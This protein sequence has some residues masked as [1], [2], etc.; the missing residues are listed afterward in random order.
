MIYNENNTR[1]KGSIDIGVDTIIPQLTLRNGT[2]ADGYVEA[3][4]AEKFTFQLFSDDISDSV[5]W[6]LQVSLDGTNWATAKDSSDTDITGTLVKDTATVESFYV[7]R[8]VLCRI[9][10]TRTTETGNVAYIIKPG[11]NDN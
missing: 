11:D 6:T 9:S 3:D 10:L 7:P 4:K 1:Y 5:T 8:R 2:L